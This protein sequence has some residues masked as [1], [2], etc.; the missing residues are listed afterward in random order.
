MIPVYYNKADN[1]ADKLDVILNVMV[2]FMMSALLSLLETG[3]SSIYLWYIICCMIHATNNIMFL[4]QNN[5]NLL[6]NTGS[7]NRFVI[8]KDH[9]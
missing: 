7:N 1:K 2:P 5:K 8:I 4:Y 3:V 9:K 6:Y